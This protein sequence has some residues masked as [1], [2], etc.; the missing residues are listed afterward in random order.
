[1]IDINA[2]NGRSDLLTDLYEI[3]MIRCVFHINVVYNS[4]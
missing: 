3:R 4:I 2:L 1:M